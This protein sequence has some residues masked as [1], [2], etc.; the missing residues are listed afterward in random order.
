V[1]GLL[2][3]LNE[4]W[5]HAGVRQFDALRPVF[6]LQ[7]LARD[8]IVGTAT[9]GGY[10]VGSAPETAADTLRPYSV[11]IA[12]GAQVL[13]SLRDTTPL[14]SISTSAS[15]AWL[16]SESTSVSASTPT[17]TSTTLSPKSYAA[18]V[19]ISRSLRLAA[20]QSEP[21]VRRHLARLCGAA[22]DAATFGGA[23]TGG[24]PSGLLTISGLGTATGTDYAACCNMLQQAVSAGAD[25][26]RSVFVS[27][28]GV[29]E[30]YQQR[31][32]GT[33]GSGFIWDD[34]R[35]CGKPA[36]AAPEMPA[37]SAVCGDFE[38]VV[39]GFWGAGL[40]LSVD[41]YSGFQT[42]VI[43]VRCIATMDVG[44]VFPGSFCKLESIS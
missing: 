26:R 23:G 42:G 37:A 18:V 3:E 11:A 34:D 21:V 38:Q 5:D 31:E 33:G 41:P 25:D 30:L 24:Q 13:G 32:R 10:L 14:T 1:T 7:V 19:K 40:E 6:P 29:R 35:I 22:V 39:C 27:T 17:F 20:G 2:R 15:G 9:L 44:V 12:A 36:Y 43:A 28:P 4:E 8:M 16:S